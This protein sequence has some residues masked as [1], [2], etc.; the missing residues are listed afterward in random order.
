M[1]RVLALLGLILGI[2]YGLP[3]TARSNSQMQSQGSWLWWIYIDEYTPQKDF[4]P[5]QETPKLKSQK[6]VRLAKKWIL[7]LTFYTFL[8]HTEN[9]SIPEYIYLF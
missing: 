1:G 2:P 7:W 5:K 4:S 3:R 9:I 8:V 6:L